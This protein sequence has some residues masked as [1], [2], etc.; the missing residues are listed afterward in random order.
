MSLMLNTDTKPN[1][2]YTKTYSPKF[3]TVGDYEIGINDFLCLV[4][5]VLTNTDL[6]PDDPRIDFVK[7]MKTAKKVQGWRSGK[8]ERLEFSELGC[9]IKGK[10]I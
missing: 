1:N 4:E 10:R 7:R 3:V 8:S 2:L 6:V 5:Y 9:K